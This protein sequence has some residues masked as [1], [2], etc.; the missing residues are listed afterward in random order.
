MRRAIVPVAIMP[1][2][3]ASVRIASVRIVPV[4]IVPV[5]EMKSAS[6]DSMVCPS[7]RTIGARPGLP[8]LITFSGHLSFIIFAGPLI[9]FARRKSS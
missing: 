3:I 8:P 1:V 4:R 2:G 7:D 9:Y 5:A 6:L